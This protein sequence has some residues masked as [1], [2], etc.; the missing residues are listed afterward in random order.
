MCFIKTHNQLNISIVPYLIWL[1]GSHRISVKE[2]SLH[3]ADESEPNAGSSCRW[4]VSA[5]G[6][7]E[8]GPDHSSFPLPPQIHCTSVSSSH[9]VLESRG[10]V[11][12]P[13]H[14]PGHRAAA[15]WLPSSGSPVDAP[16]DGHPAAARPTLQPAPFPHSDQH[17]GLTPTQLHPDPGVTSPGTQVLLP[18]AGSWLVFSRFILCTLNTPQ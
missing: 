18:T 12:M 3:K 8:K 10:C 9:G 14:P 5:G 11:L 17:C 6:D 15:D 2:L 1:Q 16:D 4:L 13:G 7:L